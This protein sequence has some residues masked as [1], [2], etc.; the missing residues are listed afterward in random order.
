MPPAMLI[1]RN[2]DASCGKQPWPSFVLI[3]GS[4]A[5]SRPAKWIWPLLQRTE[6]ALIM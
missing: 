2:T 3:Y 5:T 4:S 6:A 1:F